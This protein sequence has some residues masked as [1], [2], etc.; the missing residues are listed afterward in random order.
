[1]HC[2]GLG[3]H[4]WMPPPA[5]P[6]GELAAGTSSLPRPNQCHILCRWSF[7]HPLHTP[8]LL[9]MPRPEGRAQFPYTLPSLPR[10]LPGWGF[11]YRFGV[12]RGRDREETLTIKRL[13]PNLL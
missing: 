13:D 3:T 11:F 6:R 7:W 8:F 1:M 4:P 9:A 10:T 2:T 12:G 5:G